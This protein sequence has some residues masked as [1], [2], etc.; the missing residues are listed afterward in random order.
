MSTVAF[1]VV[2]LAG[3]FQDNFTLQPV[4]KSPSKTLCYHANKRPKLNRTFRFYLLN[5]HIYMDKCLI[6]LSELSLIRDL[7]WHVYMDDR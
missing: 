2:L 6:Y 4:L 5:N 7:T 3:V 1:V